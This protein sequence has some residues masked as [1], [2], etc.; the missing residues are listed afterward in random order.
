[1]QQKL[2]TIAVIE[3]AA[4]SREY[5]DGGGVKT[6]WRRQSS[7]GHSDIIG[8]GSIEGDGKEGSMGGSEE[9]S[10]RDS[11]GGSKGGNKGGNKGIGNR[12]G[13]KGVYSKRIAEEGVEGDGKAGSKGGSKGS[14]KKAGKT[15]AGCGVIDSNDEDSNMILS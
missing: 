2:S 14:G 4:T 13:N 7:N 1:M 10:K 8:K 15:A 3:A 9:G 6:N 5:G 11:K 12:G